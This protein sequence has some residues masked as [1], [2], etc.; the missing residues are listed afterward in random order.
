MTEIAR[1]GL[2]QAIGW[3]LPS[4]LVLTG[5][6]SAEAGA[7]AQVSLVSG[8]ESSLA[9]PLR[10]GLWLTVSGCGQRL[11]QPVGGAHRLR[12]VDPVSRLV[13]LEGVAG[14]AQ[15]L[16]GVVAAGASLKDL[17]NG[18]AAVVE[19]RVQLVAGRF[20]PFTVLEV[21]MSAAPP[22]TPL[23][24]GSGRLAALVSDPAGPGKMYAIPAE[25][26]GRVVDD[27]IQGGG[28]RRAKLGF[29][30]SPANE[31]AKLTRVL[32]GSPAA[33]AGML[34][35]DVLRSINGRPIQGY[36]DA[37][38]EMFLL[39]PGMAAQVTVLRGKVVKEFQLQAVGA[40]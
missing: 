37:V 35:G 6:L 8:G 2:R 21:R 27:L 12:A 18:A 33:G 14:R 36:G 5:E 1:C 13:L 9:S 23:M 26:I 15:G 11:G 16:A 24:D 25:V 20:L 22:G 39:K 34:A 29:A 10:D 38:H 3:V 32:P 28:L 40:E 31:A 7:L 17:R 30:L 19:R 4:I